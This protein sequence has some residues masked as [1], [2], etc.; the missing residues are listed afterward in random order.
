M[1]GKKIRI[2]IDGSVCAGAQTE[3]YHAVAALE[4]ICNTLD[5]TYGAEREARHAA[6]VAAQQRDAARADAAQARAELAEARGNNLAATMTACA[7]VTAQRDALLVERNA[8][9]DQRDAALE[10]LDYT[11]RRFV[12]MRNQRDAERERLY[13]AC[14][15]RDAVLERFDPNLLDRRRAAERKATLLGF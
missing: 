1:A 10:R 11:S 9:R 5:S 14:A 8:A 4:A 3:I 6:M 15:E 7:E 12:D 13:A 2:R